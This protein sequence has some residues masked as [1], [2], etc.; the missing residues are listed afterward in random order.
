VAHTQNKR[1]GVIQG[2]IYGLVPHTFC[3]LFVVLSVVGATAATRLIKGLLYLPYFFQI[4]IGL[5]LFFA[6]LS[7]AF[8]LRRNGLLSWEGI[9]F[10]RKY[11][12]TMY[13]TTL[14]VNLLFFYV[15]FPAVANLNS[16]TVS[17]AGV[18]ARVVAIE[19]T[20]TVTLA[21]QIPCSGHAPLVIGELKAFDGIVSTTYRSPNLFQVVYDPARITVGGILAQPVFDSFPA[22]VQE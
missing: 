13:T 4:I 2:L 12:V 19:N 3:I 14:A 10:K 6:T 18:G 20:A 16:S 11:L 8:Y 5:A 1:T 22:L 7:A 15:I 17:A 21:V 9:K